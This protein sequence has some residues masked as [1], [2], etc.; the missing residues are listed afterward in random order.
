MLA[1]PLIEDYKGKKI[2]YVES[3]PVPWVGKI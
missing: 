3:I 1:K 2:Y